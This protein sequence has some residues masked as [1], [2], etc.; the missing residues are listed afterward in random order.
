MLS[1]LVPIE[2]DLASVC[3][4]NQSNVGILGYCCDLG[5]KNANMRIG[6]ELGPSNS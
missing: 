5:A 3:Q 6:Q 1:K 2:N 4:K